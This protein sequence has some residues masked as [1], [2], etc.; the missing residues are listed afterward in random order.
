LILKFLLSIIANNKTGVACIMD[1]KTRNN[2]AG[3]LIGIGMGIGFFPILIA[4]IL[5]KKN[6]FVEIIQRMDSFWKELE[7]EQ[8]TELNNE[9]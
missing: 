6:V 3:S 8:N 5:I 2:I 9:N 7:N 4:S 1:N